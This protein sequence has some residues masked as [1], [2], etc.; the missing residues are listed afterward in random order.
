[1]G[2]TTISWCDHSINPIRA[3][4]T[5]TGSTGHYCE[6]LSAGCKNC[7]SS[8]LQARF[9]MPEFR[10]QYHSSVEPF[11]DSTR[12]D[13]VLRRKKPTKYF[14][15]DMTDLF[16]HWVSDEWIDQCFAVMALTRQHVHM[17]LTKRAQRMHEY[18]G[19]RHKDF[20]WGRINEATQAL[21]RGR[22]TRDEWVTFPAQ[23]PL[24]NVWLGVSVE[25]QATADERI[26]WLLRTPAAVRF[27]SY[28]PA[29]EAVELD[30]LWLR[31][32]PS[33]AF[34]DG[35]VPV[36]HYLANGCV[37][38]D[39]IICG[40][41]SGPRARSCDLAWLRSVVQQCQA[42]GVACWVKQVG[43]NAY[44]VSEFDRAYPLKTKHKAGADP[45]EWPSD[46]QVQQMPEGR[47]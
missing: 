39:W 27:V 2:A 6:K 22:V 33:T 24:P 30:P 46:L 44:E 21:Q 32:S 31:P 47:V 17:V 25:N 7:Y 36:G 9:G 12:F 16:G 38:L 14:W 40:G 10:A 3:R 1:M 18:F 37:G 43:A 26:P 34:L 23:R 8:R 42:V 4:H 35:R 11:L 20:P 41:E 15:C 28:E 19:T 13:E 29:L 5:P 45:A